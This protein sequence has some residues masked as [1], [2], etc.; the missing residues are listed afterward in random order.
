MGKLHALNFLE[1]VPRAQ[2]VAA[3][4]PDE[5]EL[6]WAMQHLEP[7]GVTIYKDYDEMLRHEGLEAVVIASVTTVHAEQSIKAIAA[8]KHVL[9]EK[10]LSTSTETVSPSFP[11][12]KQA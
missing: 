2:L 4:T 5:G 11:P 10:P 1:K 7:L 8:N 12:A 9:C 3:S 6:Q